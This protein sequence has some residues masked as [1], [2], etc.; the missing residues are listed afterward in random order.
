MRSKTRNDPSRSQMAALSTQPR[1]VDGLS[2]Q[3]FEELKVRHNDAVYDRPS[4]P[5][6]KES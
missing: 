2:I 6:L 4:Q 3:G 1:S 5:K